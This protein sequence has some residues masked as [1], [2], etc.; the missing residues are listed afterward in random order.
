MGGEH[1][2]VHYKECSK[3]PTQGWGLSGGKARPNPDEEK[4]FKPNDCKSCTR[5][6]STLQQGSGKDK[7]GKGATD[8][9]IVDCIKNSP[10]VKDYK[11]TGKNRYNCD[12]WA[13]Q[14]T[15]QCGLK[16]K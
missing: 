4:A 2:Y 12:D 5:T 13:N 6:D 11:A 9:E 1:T 15:S 7:S 10:I 14:A 8:A 16:C 3:C